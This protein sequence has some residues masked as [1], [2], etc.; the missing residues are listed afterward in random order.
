MVKKGLPKM[1]KSEQRPEWSD[2][3][4]C[5]REEQ[6]DS[7]TKCGSPEGARVC[8][9]WSKRPVWQTDNGEEWQGL[10]SDR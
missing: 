1:V 9:V 7:R 3:C 10:S 6:S 5:L 4:G 8:S 2:H